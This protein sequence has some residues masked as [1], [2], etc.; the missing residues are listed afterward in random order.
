MI[1][2]N[3][4]KKL[5]AKY[6]TQGINILLQEKEQRFIPLLNVKGVEY[7]TKLLFLNKYLNSSQEVC[8]L[9]QARQKLKKNLKPK[10]LSV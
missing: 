2:T 3:I 10:S 7:Y 8:L 4:I 6:V 9:S 1:E 5:S